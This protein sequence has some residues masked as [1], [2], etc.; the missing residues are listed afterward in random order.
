MPRNLNTYKN[1]LPCIGVIMWPKLTAFTALALGEALAY[2]YYNTIIITHLSLSQYYLS[3]R[4]DEADKYSL[5][6]I[7]GSF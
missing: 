4:E 2:C 6:S 7:M 1:H 3:T 5:R